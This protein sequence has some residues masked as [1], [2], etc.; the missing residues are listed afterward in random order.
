MA[1]Y[2]SF[3]QA[4]EKGN[5][6]ENDRRELTQFNKFMRMKKTKRGKNYLATQK[7]WKD[8]LGN[9]PVK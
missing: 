9:L 5:L 3:Q 1:M 8:Y 2:K 7:F 4:V 6:S